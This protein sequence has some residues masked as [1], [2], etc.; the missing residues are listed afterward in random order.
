M[1]RGLE[2]IVDPPLLLPDGGMV[3]PIR[4]APGSISFSDGAVTPQLLIPTT[5]AGIN[6][7]QFEI[8][9]V[10][11]T[12]REGFFI[13]LF[14]TPESPVKTATQVL[15]EADERNRAVSPMLVRQQ[16]ELLD[17]FIARVFFVMDR[18]QAFPEPPADLAG[19]E[20]T[21]VY[22]SPLIASQRQAES[23]GTVRLVESYQFY[24]AATGGDTAIFDNLE[25]DEVASVFHEGSGAPARV[26]RSEQDREAMREEIANQEES[27]EQAQLAIQG[28]DTVAKLVQ[29]GAIQGSVPQA[30]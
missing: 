7:G 3:S 25:T 26:M 6:L 21:V 17:P 4:L 14:I 22:N 13:P 9:K 2:K 28:G 15:Q 20:V 27:A 24:S 16:V 30:A 1:I 10:A 5:G 23:L 8:G 12:I 29:S 19:A 11:E 18:A